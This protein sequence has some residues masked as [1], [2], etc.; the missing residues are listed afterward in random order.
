M[1]LSIRGIRLTLQQL[2]KRIARITGRTVPDHII[3]NAPTIA[4]FHMAL[5][6]PQKP[7]KLFETLSKDS[8]LTK[9]PNVTLAG[10]RQTPIDK[11]MQVG[12][13]KLI[14]A[15]LQRRNLPV[16]GRG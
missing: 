8:Q 14:E 12:R 13:W 10:R 1:L 9:L 15:E 5:I 16:T 6:K 11:E 7:P 3:H 4:A 2:I